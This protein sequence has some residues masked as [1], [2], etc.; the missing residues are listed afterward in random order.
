MTNN[1]AD[2]C[3]AASG[4]DNALDVLIEVALFNPDNGWAAVRP[5]A[6]GTKVIYTRPDGT[7]A[8][9]WAHDWTITDRRRRETAA[10]LRAKEKTN[11][12]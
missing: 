7:E 10:A 1:L 2:R 5:N 8:T 6:A 3:E 11:A 12:D 9:F 4:A